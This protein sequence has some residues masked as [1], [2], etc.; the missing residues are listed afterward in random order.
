M[1]L[2]KKKSIVDLHQ[3][4]RLNKRLSF[5]YDLYLHQGI[6][7]KKLALIF[8]AALVG[9][10]ATLTNDPMV[11]IAFS[12][13]DGSEGNCILENK[14]GKWTVDVPST[15][16]IRRSDDALKFECTAEHGAKAV[17]AIPSTMGGEIAMSAIFL[18]F[19]ITDAITDMHR[20]YP[21]SF[22]IPV[23]ADSPRQSPQEKYMK[24]VKEIGEEMD[25]LQGA[26]LLSA[27]DDSEKWILDCGDGETIE[28]RCFEEACYSK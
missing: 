19:G 18:D 12:F 26:R 24:Q 17:G 11:P 22:V 2:H 21:S 9:G 14:R 16:S 5:A 8:G 27:T 20:N 1:L 13:S 25:C 15:A 10:C 28:V 4:Q 7:M 6:D 3:I 23:S